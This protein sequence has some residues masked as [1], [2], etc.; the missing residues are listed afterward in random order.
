[1]SKR[2]FSTA[3]VESDAFLDLGPMPQVL[4]LHLNMNADGD[5]FVNPKRVMRIVGAD[6]DDMKDLI[7]GRFVISFK[8]GVV[9]IKHWWINNTIRHDRHT[10]TTYQKEFA[11]LTLKDNKSYT[12]INTKLPLN[13]EVG[14][15]TAT[16]RQPVVSPIHV[17]SHVHV[18]DN[19]IQSSGAAEP[20]PAAA[21]E[22]PG[23][24]RLT[25]PA[26]ASYAK[27]VRADEAL[28]KKEAGVRDRPP[29]K[30]LESAR[31]IAAKIKLRQKAPGT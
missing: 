1:M 31:A 6:A 17:H 8:S 10:P 19:S 12:E 27:A 15:Q 29:G 20:A 9:V 24:K 21:S 7:K 18:Q 14:N 26:A 25:G 30:G 28:A 16:K 5:G 3:I 22:Q 4:Y 11:Q 23:R 13:T 2:M